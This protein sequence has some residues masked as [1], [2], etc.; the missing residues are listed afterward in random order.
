MPDTTFEEACRCP[1]CQAPSKPVNKWPGSKGSTVHILECPTE[2]CRWYKTRWVVQVNADGSVPVRKAGPKE[3]EP[4]KPYV[5]QF[6]RDALR[7]AR[8]E[9]PTLTPYLEDKGL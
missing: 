2:S 1:K 5:E 3:F 9:D 7:Q 8:A 4:Y 6:A